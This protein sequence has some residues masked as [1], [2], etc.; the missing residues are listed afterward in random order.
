MLTTFS[1]GAEIDVATGDE[2]SGAKGA[3]LSSLSDS[4]EPRP[5]RLTMA[6]AAYGVS[7][8]VIDLGRP[9]RGRI[10]GV[11]ACT[12]VG[13][14][15]FTALTGSGVSNT[16]GSVG[17]TA[18]A[19]AV[20]FLS[21]NG[22]TL[23]GFDIVFSPPAAA[24]V[25]TITVGNLLGTSNIVYTYPVPVGGG[26]FSERYPNPLSSVG[27]GAQIS[28]AVAAVVGGSA[29]SIIAFG[30]HVTSPPLC[31]FFVGDIS[32]YG[33]LQCRVP[34][35]TVPSFNTFTADGLWVH[36]SESLFIVTNGVAAGSQVAA[37]AQ[38]EEWRE[39]EISMSDGS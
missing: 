8:Q 37:V 20:L 6:G 26:T 3:I 1:L 15:S 16:T 27:P 24:F 7:P 28:I 13:A 35:L 33:L 32:N 10:W 22:D 23:T 2:L 19:S 11:I 17:I 31:S 38:I 29:G 30:Q 12:L 9:P 39:S 21:N 14:D 34:A 36:D 5:L 18:A 4:K 25:A